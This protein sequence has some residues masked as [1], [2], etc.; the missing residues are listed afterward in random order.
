M[1]QP[2]R[3]VWIALLLA[4]GPAS[5]FGLARFAYAVLLPPM[6]SDLDWSYATAAL[7]NTVNAAG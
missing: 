1:A 6:Q 4:A 2:T 5:A 7:L 3:A